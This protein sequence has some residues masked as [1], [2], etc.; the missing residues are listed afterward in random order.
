MNKPRNL[1]RPPSAFR[2]RFLPRESPRF[3]RISVRNSDISIYAWNLQNAQLT[4]RLRPLQ[5]GARSTSF[6]TLP[7]GERGRLVRNSILFGTL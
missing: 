3:R 4:W 7:I 2:V 6:S 1:E 5:Y